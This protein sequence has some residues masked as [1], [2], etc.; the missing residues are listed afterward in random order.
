MIDQMITAYELAGVIIYPQSRCKNSDS[1]PFVSKQWFIM[2]GRKVV[3]LDR[4]EVIA[5][6]L[7]KP[8][9]KIK[10]PFQMPLDRERRQ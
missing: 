4:L 1:R 7:N 10:V 2:P 8:L 9:L 3:H 5:N 6:K